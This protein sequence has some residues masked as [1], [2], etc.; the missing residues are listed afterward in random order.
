MLNDRL[1][2]IN[3]RLGRNINREVVIQQALKEI[4]DFLDID[5]V[6]LYYFYNRWK[7]QVTVENLKSSQ[8]SI[9]GETGADECFND[10]YAVLY[11]EGRVRAIADIETEP[12]H[13][14]HR[15]FLRSIQVRA[16]LVVPILT[17]EGLWGLL[18][19]H[20]CTAPRIWT[21][22]EIQFM[23]KKAEILA[24]LPAIENS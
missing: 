12:I 13:T 3:N 7:G 23:Q 17:S 6:A 18:A 4:R 20:H 15:D 16:N 1:R 21:A 5:R 22:S 11:E 9:L 14:C 8:F 24:K 19:A 2:Q 10:R